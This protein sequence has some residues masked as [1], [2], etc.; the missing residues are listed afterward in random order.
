MSTT[1]GRRPR[2]SSR[3]EQVER[4]RVRRPR[5]R[6][7]RGPA[8][9]R[10][11]PA[12]RGERPRDR[13]RSG[14]GSRRPAQPPFERRFG[15]GRDLHPDQGA[16]SGRARR[17][18][19]R[20]PISAARLRIDSRPKWPGW[21]GRRVEAAAVVAD[22]EHDARRA[23]L[24]ADPRPARA[25]VL[26]D[27]GER[28]AADAEQLGLDALARARGGRRAPAT[29]IDQPVPRAEPRARAGR[30]RR[31]SPSSTGSRPSSKISARISLCALPGQL[32]DRAQGPRRAGPDALTPS[33]SS[34]F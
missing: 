1:S 18:S 23:G 12:A 15:V 20:P 11:R 17:S 16:L 29:S 6:R 30:A 5:R 34:A 8:R 27:V 25:G 14:R 28:L 10:G 22:L 26:D 9:S 32:A 3:G 24:D 7:P 31:T 21:R 4:L 33:C 13:R 2:E 19:G